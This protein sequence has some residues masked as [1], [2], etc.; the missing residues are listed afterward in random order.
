M[1]PVIPSRSEAPAGLENAPE[2]HHHRLGFEPMKCLK[3][4]DEIERTC[5]QPR[6]FRGRRHDTNPGVR[7]GL[8]QHLRI[9]VDGYDLRA[10][11]CKQPR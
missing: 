3:A 6:L 8:G 2:L 9:W 10:A 11:L 4:G 5:G 7:F 1:V